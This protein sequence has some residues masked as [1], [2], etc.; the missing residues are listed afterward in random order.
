MSYKEFY[1]ARSIIEDFIRKDIV[2]P[3]SENEIIPAEEEDPQQY[4]SAGILYPQ[5]E[6]IKQEEI[7]EIEHDD[8]NEGID[9]SNSFN[10]SSIAISTTIKGGINIINAHINYGYYEPKKEDDDDYKHSWERN[11]YNETH[12]IDI[13]SSNSLKLDRNVSLQWNIQKEYKDNAKTITFSLVNNNKSKDYITDNKNSIFQPSIELQT[14]NNNEIFIPRRQQLGLS[15]DKEIKRFELLYSHVNNYAVGHGCSV[16]WTE[17]QNNAYKIKTSIIPE[18]E[19]K[20]MKPS[21][22]LDK[23]TFNIK[24]LFEENKINIQKR[25]QKFMDSYNDWIDNNKE[26]LNNVEPNLKEVG[27]ENIDNCIE[28]KERILN[29]LELF[30]NKE[31]GDD[32][33]KAF[34]LMN[35][36]MYL[37]RV[38]YLKNNNIEVID[39]NINWYPFQLAFILQAIPSIVNPDSKYRDIVDLLWFP[40]G[41][42]KTEAYLGLAAFTIF[43][44]RLTSENPAGVTILMR[45]TLRLLTVQQFERAA[46]LIAACELIR[47]KEFPDQTE[48]SIG[49]WV[50]GGLT[51]NKTSGNRGAVKKLELRKKGKN[52]KEGDPCQLL[53]CPWCGEDLTPA[54][55]NFSNN[56]KHTIKCSNKKCDFHDGLPI[57][58]VDENIYEYKPTFIISTIDKYARMTWEPKVGNLFGLDTEFAPPELIIQDELHLISGP[59]GTIAGLY[60]IAMKKFTEHNGINAK[61]IASTATI[62]NASE[63]IKSLYASGHKQFPPQGLDIRDS[64]YAE[65]A[66]LDEEPGRKYLGILGSGKSDVTM[67]VRVY[68]ALLLGTRHLMDLGFSNE[69]IDHYWTIIGYFNSL[70][71]L[72]GA[73]R[74]VVDDVQKRYEYL[75]DTKFDHLEPEFKKGKRQYDLLEE[76]TS[77]KDNKEIS[78]V[79]QKKLKVKYPNEAAIDFVLASNMISVGVDVNRLG[80]MVVNGQPKTNAETIQATSRIGRAYPGLAIQLYHSGRSRDRSHYEQFLYYYSSLYRYVEATSLTPFS[81]RAREKALDA[82]FISLCRHLIKELKNNDSANN[83]N[84]S[85]KA[86]DDIEQYIINHVKKVEESEVDYVIHELNKYKKRWQDHINKGDNKYYELYKKGKGEPLLKNTEELGEFQI[87]NSMRNV[88]FEANIYLEDG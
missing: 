38:Q 7:N 26:E 6:K 44:R 71:E 73:I 70:R 77:R 14:E 41:G 3:I 82:V 81:D 24:Y 22:R 5:E 46:A 57:Y 23:E 61:V 85:I 86:I 16:S 12:I 28:S 13:S 34:K 11:H 76:L 56:E 80:L 48:I 84:P 55:Y 33:F 10:P 1:K 17:G 45:Y 87:M 50:G 65:M 20:Q 79:I 27:K 47:K 74:Q 72:G 78:E 88:D 75:Y 53:L 31:K 64:Y 36:A 21:Y 32:V 29:C 39:N 68:A 42:G 52:V 40:T 63:Q 59:L 15:K 62:R 60:E 19:I 2:G 9:L 69:V 43:Y 18:H 8:I 30:D 35:K 54:N 58:M 83:F 51:P 25:I 37:Q 4:Y 66:E 67:L 49:L